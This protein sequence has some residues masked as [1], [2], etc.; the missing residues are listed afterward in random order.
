MGS[1]GRTK[2]V[3]E[4]EEKETQKQKQQ[5]KLREAKAGRGKENAMSFS[6]CPRK[7][8]GKGIR[9]GKM[10]WGSLS[11][12]APLCQDNNMDVSVC[13]RDCI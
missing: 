2:A 6:T 5:Q 9:K 10:L 12:M 11:F 7:N 1:K 13:V 8:E 4:G 3:T